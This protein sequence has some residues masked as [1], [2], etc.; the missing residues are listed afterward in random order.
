MVAR[1]AALVLAASL[2]LVCAVRAEAAS[3]EQQL[4]SDSAGGLIGLGS[5]L[6]WYPGDSSD[7]VLWHAGK[8][9]AFP[10]VDEVGLG[11]DPKG[12]AEVV[13]RGCL[14]AECGVRARRLGDG[15][16]RRVVRTN[17]VLEAAENR[18]TLAYALRGTHPG[19]YVRRRGERRARRVANGDVRQIDIGGRWVVY[20][21]RDNDDYVRIRALD[22][23]RR[24]PHAR[25]IAKD[26]QSLDDCRCTGGTT[27]ETGAQIDGGF[28]YWLETKYTD[29]TA[30]GGPSV[31]THMLRVDLASGKPVVEDFR[32]AH[33][34]SDYSAPV[35]AGGVVTYAAG[36]DA[37]GVYSAA[38]P[39]WQPTDRT[40]PVYG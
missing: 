8:V 2:C 10:D 35:V 34:V 25:V 1:L 22:Y 14:A 17:G 4:S 18:G 21:T 27:S 16:D 19:L 29:A 20:M 7:R 15:H 24:K 26:D 30:P 39:A 6:S 12:R 33:L 5:W 31:A 13:Y 11:S 9:S 28:A 3:E 32:P 38:D 23:T 36:F 40:F 37:V